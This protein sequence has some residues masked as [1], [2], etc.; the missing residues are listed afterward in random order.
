MEIK[1]YF[2]FILIDDLNV[3]G[4]LEF[5]FYRHFPDEIGDFVDSTFSR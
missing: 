1:V 4:M 2:H 3:K 5:N